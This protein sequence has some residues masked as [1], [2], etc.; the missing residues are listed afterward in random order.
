[1]MNLLARVN[2]LERQRRKMRP[3]SVKSIQQMTD[4]EL[5]QA[6]GLPAD[7]SDEELEAHVMAMDWDQIM[8]RARAEVGHTSAGSDVRE[9]P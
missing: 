4:E 7:I 6:A 9:I 5:L 3:A 8:Q 1:M 2:R